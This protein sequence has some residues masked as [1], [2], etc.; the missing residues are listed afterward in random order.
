MMGFAERIFAYLSGQ[1]IFSSVA[2]TSLHPCQQSRAIA[3][4]G[5]LVAGFIE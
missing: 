4:A 5:A 2:L 3:K 1:N